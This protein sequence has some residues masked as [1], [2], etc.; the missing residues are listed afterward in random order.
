MPTADSSWQNL[1]LPDDPRYEAWLLV[2]A[3]LQGEES[4]A[5]TEFLSAFQK[6]G[7][8]SME[9]VLNLVERMFNAYA[10]AVVAKVT[11]TVSAERRALEL[12]E[13]LE[14]TL[15]HYKKFFSHVER[16]TGIAASS[17][18]T[19]NKLRLTIRVS[20]WKTEAFRLA[21]ESEV[22]SKSSQPET[23]ALSAETPAPAATPVASSADTTNPDVGT[24]AA[25]RKPES[26]DQVEIVFLSER[27]VQIFIAGAPYKVLNYAEMGFAS[28]KNEKPVLAW[29]TLLEFART[30]GAIRIAFD[31]RRET[32]KRV[33]EIRS[34]LKAEFGL[35]T[36]P[37]RLVKKT[38]R[39]QDEPGYHAEFKIRH[40]L[41][42]GR[43]EISL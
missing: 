31:S 8:V 4:A 1:I 40:H 21:W 42:Y 17:L 6:K 25:K 7:S 33:Q 16:A 14:R 11:G 26:W 18:E 34:K 38:L 13:L 41:S 10:N 27:Q 35:A 43:D 30:R 9:D 19:E 37:F 12:E 3:F 28:Q 20:F 32:E 2:R 24:T 29:D 22:R 5:A 23:P 15:D 39:N 36:D